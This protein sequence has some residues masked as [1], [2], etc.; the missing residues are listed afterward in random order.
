MT[1]AD[2]VLNEGSTAET[3]KGKV[4]FGQYYENMDCSEN[5][6]MFLAV[7]PCTGWYWQGS[8]C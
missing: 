4:S 1:S 5:V 8:F 6:E 3:L 2:E 7:E